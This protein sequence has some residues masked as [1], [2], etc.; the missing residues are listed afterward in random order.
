MAFLVFRVHVLGVAMGSPLA[1]PTPA[2]AAL[3]PTPA[4]DASPSPSPEERPSEEECGT[5]FACVFVGAYGCARLSN[6]TDM[7]CC[8]AGQGAAPGCCPP[9]TVPGL[10]RTC[11]ASRLL[12]TCPAGGASGAGCVRN[13]V[14]ARST[15]SP[16]AS[17]AAEGLATLV[18]DLRSEQHSLSWL[19]HEADAETRTL[20]P[21]LGLVFT[22]AV[23]GLAS[24]AALWAVW[25]FL[26]TPLPRRQS[27][28]SDAW[29]KRRAGPSRSTRTRW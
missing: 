28:P 8:S 15:A 23:A 9:S 21:P 7:V 2:P 6:L 27:E 1:G 11:N 10:E 29:S 16:L 3:A 26:V 5:G 17:T 14:P 22:I 24:A 4:P 25:I 19:L 20:L 13:R 18:Q 12:P